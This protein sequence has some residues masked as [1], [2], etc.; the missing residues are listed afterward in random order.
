MVYGGSYIFLTRENKVFCVQKS[1][2]GVGGREAILSHWLYK[3]F[4][5]VQVKRVSVQDLCAQ[6]SSLRQEKGHQAMQNYTRVSH[7]YF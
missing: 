5:Y 2:Y 1:Q 7:T 6:Q 4:D 3:V